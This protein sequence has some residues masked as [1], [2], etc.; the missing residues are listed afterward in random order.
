MIRAWISNYIPQNIVNSLAPGRFKVNFRWVMSWFWWSMAEVSLVKLP[1]YECHWTILWPSSQS[2]YG[3]NRP[4]WVKTEIFNLVLLIGILTSSNDNA[5]RWMPWDL[6]DDNSTWVQVMAWCRQAT[7]HYLSQ[8]WPSSMSPYGITRPQW[9]IIY[10]C[11]THR[12]WRLVVSFL[13]VLISWGHLWRGLPPRQVMRLPL[14]SRSRR[15]APFAWNYWWGGD[16]YYSWSG[17]CQWR[18]RGYKCS[19]SWK[20][21]GNSVIL[22]QINT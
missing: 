17:Y 13:W 14:R 2:P 9:V 20:S 3:V 16:Y 1:S 4:Q 5:L 11:L 8:C 18:T 10:S 15:V 22:C 21:H 12:W 7:S 6:T 19:R